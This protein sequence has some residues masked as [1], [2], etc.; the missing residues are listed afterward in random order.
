M[1]R[2]KI[3]EHNIDWRAA[4][5]EIYQLALHKIYAEEKS[6]EACHKVVAAVNFALAAALLPYSY[7]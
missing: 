4:A 6:R 2:D 3:E 1:G 5:S 7:H